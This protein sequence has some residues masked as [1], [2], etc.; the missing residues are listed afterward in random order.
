MGPNWKNQH[1]AELRQKVC[2]SIQD[3][4]LQRGL[5][6]LDGELE[7]FATKK[8]KKAVAKLESDRLYRNEDFPRPETA[9]AC[10]T[11]HPKSIL[12]TLCHLYFHIYSILA[13]YIAQI[14][15]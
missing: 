13:K 9:C 5:P 7:R 6:N 14:V 4:V 3:L 1:F 11:Y 10:A 15:I 2:S 12:F 8:M